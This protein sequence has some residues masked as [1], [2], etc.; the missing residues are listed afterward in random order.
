[1][2]IATTTNTIRKFMDSI[3]VLVV[4]V[5]LAFLAYIY[6]IGTD[7]LWLDEAESLL[8]ARLPFTAIDDAA[9]GSNHAPVYY[10]VLKA[11]TLVAGESTAMLRMPSALFMVASIPLVYSIARIINSKSAFFATIVFASAPY[12]YEYAQEA[13][14]YAMTVFCVAAVL[15]FAIYIIKKR[16]VEDSVPSNALRIRL[17][18]LGVAVSSV[19]LMGVHHS[20]V[21]IP[22]AV[23]LVLLAI[24][25]FRPNTVRDLVNLLLAVVLM[26]LL[27]GFLFASEFLT[28]MRS[29]GA[30]EYDITT[31]AFI[32]RIGLVYVGAYPP[33]FWLGLIILLLPIMVTA[34]VWVKNL[35]WQWIILFTTLVIGFI[36]ANIT[37]S[38][39]YTDTL[40]FRSFIWTLVPIS[41]VVGFGISRL[42]P[43]P[44]LW[45]LVL[46]LVN[47]S[48]IAAYLESN[49]GGWDSITDI[50]ES[51][52]QEGDAVV[53]CPWYFQRPFILEWDLE[54]EVVYGTIGHRIYALPDFESTRKGW[55]YKLGSV[56]QD[57]FVMHDKIWI[58]EGWGSCQILDSWDKTF[59]HAHISGKRVHEYT[60][61]VLTVK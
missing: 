14:P 26:W 21:L 13:R 18:W 28:S 12:I 51:K 7:P 20:M 46:V 11:F 1:M 16:S 52:Y 40:R 48:S 45:L 57:D 56:M 53:I 3:W 47:V 41:I 24:L 9:A 25:K 5:P 34:W 32:K 60:I 6:Q 31:W 23:L 50:I 49:Q 36:V 54:P 22:P 59:V 15:F 39:F 44:A 29:F 43:N 61:G 17:V 19:V 30:Y 8:W 10:T 35:S 33:I 4:I 55:R 38:S 42:K 58:I 37:I 2:A 27:Y